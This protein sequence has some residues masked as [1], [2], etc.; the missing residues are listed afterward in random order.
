MRAFIWILRGLAFFLLLGFAL[1]NDALVT[2]RFFFETEWRLPLIAVILAAFAL[3]LVLGVTA[4]VLTLLHQRREI[5]RLRE[6]SRDPVLREGL[7]PVDYPR[8]T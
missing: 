7:S 2:L 1:K 5:R 6:T 4:A 8:S 3:G